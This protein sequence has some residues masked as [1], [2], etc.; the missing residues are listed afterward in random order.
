MMIVTA[1]PISSLPREV[2]LEVPRGYVPSRYANYDKKFYQHNRMFYIA[3]ILKKI[4]NEIET[5]GYLSAATKFIQYKQDESH[6]LEHDWEHYENRSYYDA[7]LSFLK[8]MNSGLVIVNTE[9]I[10]FVTKHPLSDDE[11]KIVGWE[12]RDKKTLGYFS[13]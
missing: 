7:G 2:Q 5:N 6:G 4:L 3:G 1:Y 13:F 11:E 12:A 9:N 8:Q 10:N